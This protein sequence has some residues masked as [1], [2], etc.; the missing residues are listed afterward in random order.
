MLDQLEAARDTILK[1]TSTWTHSPQWILKW[2]QIQ[3]TGIMDTVPL[4]EWIQTIRA[5]ML[6]M[7]Q[8]RG[9]SALRRKIHQMLPQQME[10]LAIST[11]KSLSRHQRP[12]QLLV[13]TRGLAR[14]RNC[15]G[16]R[17]WFL[18]IMR[19]LVPWRN[20]SPKISML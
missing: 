18:A 17:S 19:G 6:T 8:S 2:R 13:N 4:H 3:S 12:N 1:L 20:C 11:K 15:L 5:L 7:Q 9:L 16:K 14:W 10:I